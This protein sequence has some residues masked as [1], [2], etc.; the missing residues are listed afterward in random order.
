M[1]YEDSKIDQPTCWKLP[2]PCTARKV[3]ACLWVSQTIL[4]PTSS[5]L[6]QLV[7]WV[8]GF[9]VFS[10]RQRD[11]Y[12]ATVRDK[13]S[14]LS[15]H[16]LLF[17]EI[18]RDRYI[19]NVKTMNSKLDSIRNACRWSETWVNKTKQWLLRPKEDSLGVYSNIMVKK[20]QFRLMM[21]VMNG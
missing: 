19:K 11:S 2:P 15:D 3:S 21:Y 12:I 8:R 10:G 16:L 18:C 7:P 20:K 6:K 14:V 13:A 17:L 4:A 1:L 5:N 9:V